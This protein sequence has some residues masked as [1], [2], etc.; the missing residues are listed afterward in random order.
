MLFGVPEDLVHT[1]V[2]V[3][4][5]KWDMGN[6]IAGGQTWKKSRE[7]EAEE[8]NDLLFCKSCDVPLRFGE[9]KLRSKWVLSCSR[10]GSLLELLMS[11]ITT[12][13]SCK[14]VIYIDTKCL[15]FIFERNTYAFIIWPDFSSP[16][17][18]RKKCGLAWEEIWILYEVRIEISLSV[19]ST[20]IPP[21]SIR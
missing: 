18:I 15:K 10:K 2:G 20:Y 16:V 8:V 19:R 11:W 9:N 4:Q 5:G 13:G 7:S 12:H 21:P 3:S 1:F 17:R 6:H 14:A